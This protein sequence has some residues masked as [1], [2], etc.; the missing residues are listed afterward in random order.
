MF[1]EYLL[2]NL[3]DERIGET[4]EW[5]WTQLTK[6]SSYCSY[7][8]RLNGFLI[9]AEGIQWSQ[10]RVLWPQGRDHRRQ[11]RQGMEQPCNATGVAWGGVQSWI[12]S[13]NSVPEIKIQIRKWKCCIWWLQ[14][15]TK[16]QRNSWGCPPVFF[17]SMSISMDNEQEI[18]SS[19]PWLITLLMRRSFVSL[20]SFCISDKCH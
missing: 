1:S 14:R 2:I 16:G 10:L 7:I 9:N 12:R 6:G 18:H 8:L 13:C 15:V 17:C 20:E 19:G 4:M 5:V 11:Y 3:Y